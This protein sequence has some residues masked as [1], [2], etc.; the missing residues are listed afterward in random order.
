M[1]LATLTLLCPVSIAPAS[2]VGETFEEAA[3]AIEDGMAEGD[4]SALDDRFDLERIVAA[5]LEG[6]DV[7]E[8]EVEEFRSGLEGGLQLGEQIVSEM[9]S[10]DG[11]F[12]LLRMLSGGRALFRDASDAGLNYHE[13]QF[14]RDEDGKVHIVDG[15]TYALGKTM[16]EQ[17]AETAELTLAVPANEEAERLQEEYF[18]SIADLV[19][20]AQLVVADPEEA[21]SIYEQLPSSV[22]QRQDALLL[23]IRAASWVGEEELTEASELFLE[24]HPDSDALL[25]L[26]IDLY[27]LREDYAACRE[28]VDALDEHVD[29]PYLDLLRATAYLLEGEADQAVE[30]AS[31][32]VERDELLEYEVLFFLVEVGLAQDD[33]ELTLKALLALEFDY[34]IEWDD[35]TDYEEFAAFVASDAYDR[36]L[37]RYEDDEEV[38]DDEQENA[39]APSLFAVA[40]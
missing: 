19:R 39:C 16:V 38:D 23:R 4:A 13:F 20:L 7:S 29:D 28:A 18:E 21:L 31:R 22:Q 15:Y 17:L 30:L 33:H 10:F 26:L 34:G 6:L 24:L 40:R 14:A 11:T 8:E 35:L 32:C 37:R 3:R 2:R 5:S 1:L 25:L 9:E 12:R 27:F 36:W